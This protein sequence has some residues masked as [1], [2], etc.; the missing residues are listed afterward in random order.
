ML[1]KNE[2]LT[3][4]NASPADAEILANWW[5]DGDVMAHAGF[6]NG[7]GTTPERIAESLAKDS[8][9]V[10]RR[11]IIEEDGM[12]IGEMNYITLPGFLFSFFFVKEG[13]LPAGIKL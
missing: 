4:R 12:P 6:P 11:H 7:L 2:N 13:K 9:G 1:L 5:N 3:I 10:H 8:E